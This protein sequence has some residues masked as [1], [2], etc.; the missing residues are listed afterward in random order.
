MRI[1]QTGNILGHNFVEVE[2]RLRCLDF[3]EP[4]LNI[5][6]VELERIPLPFIRGIALC[7]EP[8]KGSEVLQLLFGSELGKGDAR[9][10][11]DC[12]QP[13]IQRHGSLPG[14]LV[15]LTPCQSYWE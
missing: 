3:S 15:H 14:G 5:Q 7:V 2:I 12:Q 8:R 1:V 10:E 4:R 13:K 11:S 9:S 6:K